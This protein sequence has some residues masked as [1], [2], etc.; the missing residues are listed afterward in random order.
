[1]CTLRCCGHVVNATDPAGKPPVVQPLAS[2]LPGR[3]DMLARTIVEGERY[4]MEKY[5]QLR[6]LCRA[7]DAVH[8]AETEL[9]ALIGNDGLSQKVTEWRRC[10]GV[11]APR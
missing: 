11:D 1:M 2:V 10:L 5:G 4:M 7:D 9:I 3:I 8:D 6:V